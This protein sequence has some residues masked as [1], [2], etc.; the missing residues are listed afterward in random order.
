MCTYAEF[1]LLAY[2]WLTLRLGL[3]SGE[4]TPSP[5]SR[6]LSALS[7]QSMNSVNSGVSLRARPVA[8]ARKPRPISIAV[9]GI[10]QEP[11]SQT[12]RTSH[13]HSELLFLLFTLFSGHGT[14]E[15]AV[16]YTSDIFTLLCVVFYAVHIYEYQNTSVSVATRLLT[17]SCRN[18][19]SIPDREARH[20]SL[21]CS[22]YSSFGSHPTFYPMGIR[23]SLLG[24]K[25][26]EQEAAA[27]SV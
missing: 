9:T 24:V 22:I 16:N 6:P 14:Y 12:V 15:G 26:L 10:T 4:V 11:D 20:F 17:V 23:R 8:A 18:Q 3:R 5:P 7:Q 19:C 2:G 21:L 25:C 1:L 13:R 27:H